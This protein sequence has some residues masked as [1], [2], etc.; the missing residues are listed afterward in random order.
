MEELVR[1]NRSLHQRIAA[2]QLTEREL[3]SD[4]QDF[5]RRLTANQKRHD[6]RR[7]QW[8]QELENREKV[9]E[10]RIKGLEARLARQE[11]ELMRIALERSTGT[12]LTDNAIMSWLS[13][14]AGAWRAWAEDFS[15]RDQHRLQSGLH[16]VQVLELCEGVKHFVQLTEN[17]ELPN[18]L[19]TLSDAG[20]GVQVTQLLLH[21]MLSNFIISE[22]L[23]SP[24]WVFDV[25]SARGLELESP[26]V[27]PMNPGSPVG[28]RMDLAMWNFTVAPPRDARL[29][30]SPTVAAAPQAT[31]HGIGKL[32]RLATS[33]RPLVP[34][35][36]ETMSLLD[37]NL[38]SRQEMEGLYHVLCNGMSPS[39]TDGYLL[40]RI[41]DH[42]LAIEGLANQCFKTSPVRGG[43]DNARVW[44]SAVMKAFCEGGMSTEVDSAVTESV[45]V[46]AE[47]RHAYAGRLKD[48][49]LRG[50]TRFLLQDQDAAGIEKLERRL[51]REI[52][53]A[54]RFSCQL[55][56]RQDTPRVRGFRDLLSTTFKS[57]NNWIELWQGQAPV[58]HQ[59]ARESSERGDAPPGHHDG[60]PILMVIQPAIE[61]GTATQAKANSKVWAKAKV[62]V[63][64]PLLSQEQPATTNA[65]SPKTVPAGVV[66]EKSHPL[67][68]PPP[69]PTKTLRSPPKDP[70][71]AGLV[72]LPNVAFNATTRSSSEAFAEHVWTNN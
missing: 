72:M 52:D 43:V 70:K 39:T 34:S 12:T 47:A 33:V 14:K 62:L 7:R 65:A 30:Q 48:V 44:R 63:A 45:R 38:P 2:L 3:L 24:F 71:G 10:A 15:H 32:P 41:L 5:A 29:P 59:F 13:T 46:L 8:K 20:D 66:V 60:Q 28:F 11:E 53:A 55:W 57:S 37:Q 61:V 42:K 36:T 69:A 21:G 56:C 23:A 51:L 4:N 6:T 68:T 58:H 16:P 67:D 64:T 31:S 22:I 1:E 17:G 9:S 26:S 25:L 19:L 18:E 50:A 27:K 40:C 54:L 35:I 49:F